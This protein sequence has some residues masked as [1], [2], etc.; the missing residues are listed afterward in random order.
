MNIKHTSEIIGYVCSSRSCTE[1]KMAV[2]GRDITLDYRK[3]PEQASLQ[4]A[5]HNKVDRQMESEPRS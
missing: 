4:L 3:T 5:K 2:K 1:W